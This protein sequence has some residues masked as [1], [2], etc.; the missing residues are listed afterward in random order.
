MA[1]V[2]AIEDGKVLET[3]PTV[4]FVEGDLIGVAKARA[5]LIKLL[6]E[7]SPVPA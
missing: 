1:P 4:L 5:N 6:C 2:A 7:V 3:L